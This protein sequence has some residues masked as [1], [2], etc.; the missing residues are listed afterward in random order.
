MQDPHA[1]TPFVA[2]SA[3]AREEDRK[4]ALA[5]GFQAHI[6]KPFEAEELLGVAARL[7]SESRD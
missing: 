2:L 1:R 4:R 3:Y 5:A 7:I 6:G